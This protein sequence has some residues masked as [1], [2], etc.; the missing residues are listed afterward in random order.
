MHTQAYFQIQ[1]QI[2]AQSKAACCKEAVEYGV[3][4]QLMCVEH[5]PPKLQAAAN[6]AA[7]N[8]AAASAA[9]RAEA[10]DHH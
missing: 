4:Q 2:E 3:Q 9:S 10:M 8:S 6:S 7:A 5:R 1:T